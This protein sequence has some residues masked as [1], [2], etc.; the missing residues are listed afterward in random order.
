MC[1]SIVSFKHPIPDDNDSTGES[2]QGDTDGVPAL[3]LVAAF[4]SITTH[5]CALD[6]KFSLREAPFRLV[7]PLLGHCPNRGRLPATHHQLRHPKTTC[8]WGSR[9]FSWYAWSSVL[10]VLAESWGIRFI[11][12]PAMIH[13]LYV[14]N[15][16][17]P[18]ATLGNHMNKMHVHLDSIFGTLWECGK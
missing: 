14:E 4:A 5:I 13:V 7:P 1:S 2:S 9:R 6:V 11:V 8:G 10:G 17:L 15:N 18:S 12:A 16:F 3:S